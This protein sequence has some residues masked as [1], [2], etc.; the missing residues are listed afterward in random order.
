MKAATT[1]SAIK[2]IVKDVLDYADFRYNTLTAR[3]EICVDGKTWKP[4]C[5]RD[6][7]TMVIDLGDIYSYSRVKTVLNSR[8]IPEFNPVKAMIDGNK[9]DGQDRISSLLSTLQ[10]ENQK[11]SDK[12]L[13]KWFISMVAC[14][15]NAGVIPQGV[16]VLS[17]AQGVGKTTWGNKLLP[18]ELEDY[19]H[20]GYFNPDN[21]DSVLKL[22]E[23]ILISLDELDVMNKSTT[24]ALKEIITR[25]KIDE[26]RVYQHFSEISPRIASFI[27]STNEGS[28]LNDPTGSRRYYVVRVK[29]IDY[30]HDIDMVQCWAQAWYE[31]ENGYDC[32]LTNTD[33]SEIED[34][35]SNFTLASTEDDLISKH[36]EKVEIEDAEI[37]LTATEIV[38]KLEEL[39]GIDLPENAP[40][41]FGKLLSSQGFKR[42]K[43]HNGNKYAVRL[44][45]PNDENKDVLLS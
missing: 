18:A 44:K 28:F 16:F 34:N 5:D 33:I 1:T 8:K 24:S 42:K 13:R 45:H 35:N 23:K 39:E 15:M 27:G 26:R 37:F 10:A 40:L 11:F 12:Y 29:S 19:R 3:V 25:D 20:S 30:T 43:F 2:D 31:F 22:S 36:F 32:Y 7:N 41:K 38:K 4:I 17:G 14:A 9:W 21:K 6:V